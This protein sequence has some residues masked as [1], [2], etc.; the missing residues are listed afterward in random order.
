MCINL[1]RGESRLFRVTLGRTLSLRNL[2]DVHQLSDEQL[3]DELLEDAAGVRAVFSG[4]TLRMCIDLR[5]SNWK[6]P[7]IFLVTK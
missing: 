5:L 2:A 6:M 1:R 3:A 4:E 7:H